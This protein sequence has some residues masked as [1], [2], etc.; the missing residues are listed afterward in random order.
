MNTKKSVSSEALEA[1][2]SPPDSVRGSQ[3]LHRENFRRSVPLPAVRLRDAALCS[4]FMKRLS[5][6]LLRFPTIKRVVNDT[7]E[8]GKVNTGCVDFVSFFF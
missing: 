5:H 8:D 2:F 3:V 7:G 1:F 6:A 4:R